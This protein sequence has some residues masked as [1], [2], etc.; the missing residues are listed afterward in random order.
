MVGAHVILNGAV[1]WPS[2][3]PE[4]ARPSIHWDWSHCLRPELAAADDSGAVPTTAF[5][6]EGCHLQALKVFQTHFVEDIY[7]DWLMSFS[8]VPYLE[9]ELAEIP[10]MFEKL[11]VR[12]K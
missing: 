6:P 1:K 11:Y 5:I 10:T 7:L 3:F 4:S 2:K 8:T 9:A 12:S